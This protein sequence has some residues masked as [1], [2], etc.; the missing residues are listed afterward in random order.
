MFIWRFYFFIV[1]RQNNLLKIIVKDTGK[2][3]PKKELPYI[4]ERFY[5]VEKSRARAHGGMGLGL[6]IVRELVHAHGGE[7]T[8]VSE[9]N[10]GTTFELLFKG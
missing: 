9:E 5:R 8:V 3:I 1:K 10:K 2:G 6:A 7:V 4:F